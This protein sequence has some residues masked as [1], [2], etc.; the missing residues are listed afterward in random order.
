MQP[1]PDALSD[2]LIQQDVSLRELSRRTMADGDWGRPSS[3]SLLMRGEMPPTYEAM[4][5][6]AKALHVSPRY[7][8]EYRLAETRRRLDPRHVPL[9]E[10]LA[11]DAAV[12]KL[13]VYRQR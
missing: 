7:F 8:A 6:I 9:E 10:A 13:A 3:L 12:R 2:L 1:F 5:R 11:L 4:E